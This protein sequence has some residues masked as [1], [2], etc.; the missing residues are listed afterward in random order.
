MEWL[1]ETAQ[2]SERTSGTSA[3]GGERDGS[4]PAALASGAASLACALL[5]RGFISS[6]WHS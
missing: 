1:H 2:L 3:E 5:V 6:S 4:S